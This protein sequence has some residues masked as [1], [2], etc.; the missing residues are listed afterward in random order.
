MTS[1]RWTRS[2]AVSLALTTILLFVWY[3]A[4]IPAQHPVGPGSYASLLAPRTGGSAFPGPLQVW[5][6]ARQLFAHPFLARGPN[7]SGILLQLGFSLLRVLAGFLLAALV[8][9]PLG[10]VIGLSP[11]WR[12]AL[13]PFIQILRPI[14]PL[15]WMPLA[16]YTIK[17]ANASSV[18]VI[19]VCALWP[20]LLSTSHGVSIVPPAWLRV[21]HTLETGRVRLALSVILPA[22]APAIVNGMRVS[23]GIAWLVIVAAEMLVGGRGI[24]AFVW[25]SWNDLSLSRVLVAIFLIG[26]VGMG[27]DALF[28]RLARRVSYEA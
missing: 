24:G 2:A 12:Q 19:F 11:M 1:P 25:N 15:A 20:M 23:M 4:T 18:F 8:A 16:L 9:L 7:R 6:S 10:F 22:C 14:S 27:L 5:D 28:A 21:A 13:G 17:G 26:V 3:V